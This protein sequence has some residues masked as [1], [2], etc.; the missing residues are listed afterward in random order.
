MEKRAIQTERF[1]V[2]LPTALVY[3]ALI[4][5]F[6]AYLCFGSRMPWP[7]AI[8][9]GAGLGGWYGSLQHEVVHGRPTSSARLN[10]GLVW[11]PLSLTY[12]FLRYVATHVEHHSIHQLT[13]PGVDPESNFVTP[14]QWARFGTMRRRWLWVHRTLAGRMILGPMRSTCQLIWSEARAIAQ[15]DA[16]VLA[17][18]AHH[19]A[20]CVVVGWLVRMSDLTWWEYT[21]GVGYGGLSLTMLRSF[22]EHLDVVEGTPTAYVESGPFFSLLFLNN[23]LHFA[24]HARPGLPWYRLP[25]AGREMRAAEASA[26]GAGHYRGYRQLFAR[27]LLRPLSHPVNALSARVAG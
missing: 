26:R 21:I 5:G 27:Y 25:A 2:D 12:P 14:E 4:S 20:G 7:V 6:T 3:V 17:A 1:D 9:V 11:L 19:L 13:I 10:R 16:A 24:H 15:G 23:N 22:A 18:W 8:A